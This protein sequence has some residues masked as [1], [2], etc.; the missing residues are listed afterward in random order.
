[1]RG[2]D[3]AECKQ[4]ARF[5]RRK[6]SG[7]DYSLCGP[8]SKWAKGK[9]TAFQADGALY[10][11]RRRKEKTKLTHASSLPLDTEGAGQGEAGD[12]PGDSAST[13]KAKL[14]ETEKEGGF[15]RISAFDRN[16]VP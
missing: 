6:N 5:A 16:S 10:V 13:K 11:R 4:F 15:D 12:E 3:G 8:C 9:Q 2:Q 7:E 14:C 1:M